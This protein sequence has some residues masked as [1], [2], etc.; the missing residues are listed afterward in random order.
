MVLLTSGW[1]YAEIIGL[2]DA[3]EH[4]LGESHGLSIVAPLVDIADTATRR[5]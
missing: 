1:R 5:Y 4:P 3:S 2:P